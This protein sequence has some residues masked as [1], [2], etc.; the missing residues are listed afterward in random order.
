MIQNRLS[1]LAFLTVLNVSV[2]QNSPKF[3]SV[4]RKI[5][6]STATLIKTRHFFV[7]M[8]S[9][10]FHK[11]EAKPPSSRIPRPP[12]PLLR[13][14]SQ[15]KIP[16]DGVH[17]WMRIRAALRPGPFSQTYPHPP[18]H[19]QW[20]P[21]GGCWSPASHLGGG[22]TKGQ[23]LLKKRTLKKKYLPTYRGVI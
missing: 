3:W 6:L 10:G 18:P 5:S 1:I 21:E 4:S 22:G 12:P 9:G 11:H 20:P 7:E 19:T 2:V 14:P 8:V 13:S 16:D 15:K 17:P 23:I